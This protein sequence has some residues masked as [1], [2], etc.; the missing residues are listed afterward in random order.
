MT[1]QK[2]KEPNAHDEE[3]SLFEEKKEPGKKGRGKFFIILLILL[4]VAMFWPKPSIKGEAVLQAGKFTRIGLTSSGT[5]KEILHENGAIVKKG[6][7][8]A[9]FDNPEV[10]RRFEEKK[11]V[12]E[13]AI[14]DKERLGRKVEFLSQDKTRKQ[15][16][17]ENGVIGRALLEKST[18]DLE[19]A[20]EESTIKS[21]EIESVEGEVNFLK[22][23]LDSLEIKAP[24]DGMILTGSEAPVGSIF[25]EGEFIIEFADP[26][27]FYLEMLIPEKRIR[28]V[29]LGNIAIARFQAI[30]G[31]TFEGSIVRVA[32][33]ATDEVEKV[34][35][36]KHVVACEIRLKNQP[37]DVKY[38]MRALVEL[39][40]SKERSDK[41]DD[42]PTRI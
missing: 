21:K 38:G 4:G 3:P 25:R 28:E 18:H 40:T 42:R 31:R 7:V 34:F 37:P 13:I 39:K 35:K 24:F 6:E 12:F 27:S 11:T 26:E 14:L 29:G 30:P 22:K 10:E 33:R 23:R 8:L 16:L 2:P 17:F 9:R 1:E 5:L 36:I 19:E 41:K 15:I 32:P 20:Q